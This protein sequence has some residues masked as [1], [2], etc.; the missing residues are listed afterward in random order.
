MLTFIFLFVIALM[1]IAGVFIAIEAK[2]RARPD[3]TKVPAAINDQ[4]SM[5]RAMPVD[6]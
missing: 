5:G 2:R 1:A 6:D 3:T 4:P